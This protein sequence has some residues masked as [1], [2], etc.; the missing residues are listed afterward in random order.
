MDGRAGRGTRVRR[1]AFFWWGV[2]AFHLA[3]ASAWWWFMPGG[4]P[5]GHP[6]FWANGG[7]PAMVAVIALVGMFGLISGRLWL[8][9]FA[10]TLLAALWT[11][12]GMTML[13]LFPQSHSLPAV[14]VFVVGALLW[15]RWRR[16]EKLP[17]TQAT[18]VGDM[19]PTVRSRAQNMGLACALAGGIT[20]GAV[21]P[22][23]QRGPAADTR[24]LGVS[25][26]VLAPGDPNA[27]PPVSVELCQG[28]S[29]HPGPATLCVRRGGLT[30]DIAPLLTFQSR[31]PDRFWTSLAKPADRIGPSRSLL[32]IQRREDG[33]ALQY[34]S[35]GRELLD[36]V[37]SDGARAGGVEVTAFCELPRDVFSHLNSLTELSVF[38]HKE[39]ALSFSPCSDV[40]VEVT[41]SDYP[42]G[43]PRRCAYL[44]AASEFC[45]VEAASGEKGPFRRLASGPLKR[46]DPLTITLHDAGRPACSVT[47][48]DWSAQCGTQLSPTAGWGVPV[49]AIEFTRGGD[50][51]SSPAII[52]ITLAGTSIGR[53]WDS[54]GHAA[55]VYRNRLRIDAAADVDGPP[56]RSAK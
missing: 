34:Q 54:V 51:P 33:V 4:F 37:C 14:W 19:Q 23:T 32:G 1:G 56:Q 36:V 47:L 28:V 38:G 10:A 2:F 50:S 30:L 15:L 16:L 21:L 3:A 20:M 45:V 9:R 40:L 41:P 8:V 49:N 13:L 25:P 46:G 22:W 43:R 31:S 42:V 35:D 17:T 12:A 44:D 29:V 24:P 5:V 52:W 6:R 11:T 27:A 39:L 18:D 48:L 7:L 53:G 26:P 55:G